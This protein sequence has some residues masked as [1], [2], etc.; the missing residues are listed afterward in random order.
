[1]FQWNY[2][3]KDW[4]NDLLS[5]GLTYIDVYHCRIILRVN[6]CLT[7]WRHHIQKT[8]VGKAFSLLKL[9]NY[10]VNINLY[11]RTRISYP[12]IK[13]I[14]LRSLHSF[15]IV[16]SSYLEC[17]KSRNSMVTIYISVVS[18][19][20]E[21]FGNC[22]GWKLFTDKIKYFSRSRNN[23]NDDIFCS[24]YHCTLPEWDRQITLYM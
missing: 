17:H 7:S 4:L 19:K 1:M 3:Q 6:R 9:F 11:T 21:V 15:S 20:K 23:C 14:F 5:Q 13:M 2:F 16:L 12:Y 24:V 18:M 22:I 8:N 10:L